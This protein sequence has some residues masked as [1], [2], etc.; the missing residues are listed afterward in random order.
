MSQIEGARPSQLAWLSRQSVVASA[1]LLLGLI[2]MF[3]P[4]FNHVARTV[5]NTDEQGHG[6]IILAVVGWLLWQRRNLLAA[7]IDAG[8]PGGVTAWCC[9]VFGLMLHFVGRLQNIIM[10]EMFSL[11]PL[12]AGAFAVAFGWAVV[13]ISAFPLFFLIFA[14]PLPGPAVDALTSPLK[15]AVSWVGEQILWRTGYPISRSGVVLMVGQYQLLVADA[16]AGL[17]SMF[18]LEALGLLYMNLMG[19]TNRIRNVML[20]ILIIPMSFTAN[21]IRV[22]VLVL[23]TYHFGDEAG[24]GIV[25]GAA[26]MLLFGVAL[27]LMI[28]IDSALGFIF[29]KDKVQR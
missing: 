2:V 13:R 11:I 17:N 23:V 26:G 1:L 29:P 20:A 15:Q 18:T 14:V 4:V 22:I 19:H 12:L 9:L 25:H 3:A 7:A 5:W 27:G 21:V 24:Q 8:K 28:L 16:C 6:P 10:F